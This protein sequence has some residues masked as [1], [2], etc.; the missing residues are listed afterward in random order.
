MQDILAKIDDL[1]ARSLAELQQVSA[2]ADLEKWRIHYLGTSGEVRTAS[3][4]IK[5]AQGPDKKAVGQRVNTMKNEVNQAFEQKKAGLTT[6]VS[7]AKDYIDV[8]EPG[9]K[10][11][12]GRTHVITQVT[13]EL[14]ELFG[15]MGF[16]VAAGPEVEDEF[17]NFVALNIPQSHPARDPLDNFYLTAPDSGLSTQDFSS[18]PRPAP[19]RSA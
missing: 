3:D 16:T 14:T 8:T 2:A 15:R 12:I 18:A 11:E 7:A 1:R 13:N 6:D 10:P 4:L 9:A 19:C 17:H 5:L